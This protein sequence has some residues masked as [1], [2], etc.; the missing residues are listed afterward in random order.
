LRAESIHEVA[1]KELLF[2]GLLGLYFVIALIRLSF[3]KYF[4]DLFRLFFRTT[5]R[6]RHLSEQ[7][8]QSPLPSFLL[9]A[10]FFIAAG[11]YLSLWISYEEQNP[12]NNFSWLLLYVCRLSLKIRNAAIDRLAIPRP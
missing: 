3:P 2:Y 9:N 7:M 8:S 11:L 10:I 5:I 6:Q 1:G 4:N 12:F